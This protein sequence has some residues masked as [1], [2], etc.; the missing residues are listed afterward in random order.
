MN[1]YLLFAQANFQ[2]SVATITVWVNINSLNF[3]TD[4]TKVLT[5]GNPP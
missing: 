1:K 5:V 4:R 2:N 3:N